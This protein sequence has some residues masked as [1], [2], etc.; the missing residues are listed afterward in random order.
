FL[1]IP[2]EAV[3]EID[4]KHFVYLVEAPDRYVKREVVVSNVSGGQVRVLEGV[5]SGQRIVTKGAVLVK[6]QEVK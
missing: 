6:G 1:A 3:V 4:G 5:T 2:K